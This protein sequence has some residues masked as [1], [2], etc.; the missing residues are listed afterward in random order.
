MRRHLSPFVFSAVRRGSIRRLA[1]D[2]AAPLDHHQ[3]WV[4]DESAGVWRVDVMVEPGDDRWWV[5]RRDGRIRR[6]RRDMVAWSSGGVPYLRPEGALLYKAGAMSSKDEHDFALCFERM[7]VRARTWLA[8]A[9]RI[10]HPEHP[11]L[12]RLHS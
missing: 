4:H 9:L 1:P 3:H 12:D 8:E 5:Y 7:D 11:W 10:V 6:P 2:E